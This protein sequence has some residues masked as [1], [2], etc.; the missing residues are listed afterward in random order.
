METLGDGTFAGTW[1]VSRP[2]RHT[3]WVEAMAHG[4]LFDSEHP[5]DTLVWGMPYLVGALDSD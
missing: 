3:A 2:G 1:T 4:T 5:D